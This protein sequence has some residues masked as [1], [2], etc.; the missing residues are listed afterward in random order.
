M[1]TSRAACLVAIAGLALAPAQS[2]A[3]NERVGTSVFQ[4]LRIGVGA[5]AMGMGGAFTAV[6]DDA[7]GIYWNPAGIAMVPIREVATSYLSYF[8][9][10]HAGGVAL[11][12]PVGPRAT[13]GLAAQFLRVG[14][15]PTT[16]VDNQTGQGL[17]PFS[18]NDLAISAGFGGRV[19]GG[20]YAGVAGS[21]LYE[22]I[23]A[24]DGY[25]STAVTATLGALYR[26]GFRH[27][28]VG[29]V[30]RHLGGQVSIYQFAEE[31]LPI[32]FAA[33]VATRAFWERLLVAVD[34]EKPS[35]DDAGV[36][37]G[38][39][40]QVVRD[41]FVRAGYRSLDARVGD[42]AASNGDIAGL[43]F[44]IGVSGNRRYRVDYAY[45]S[46]ADL[47]DAHRVSLALVLR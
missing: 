35:D 24:F 9:D 10:V 46:F 8:S 1:K 28:S 15:I 27:T 3:D 43:T 4:F 33:G 19:R 16:T 29:A 12:E 2:A 18:M 25:A 20:L 17:D 11:A 31:D 34:V 13:L 45:S 22:G 40:C 39:E 26:S 14:D 44:G 6:S 32:T 23:T 36:N 38:A 42:E 30:V 5:R 41:F 47:G 37:A 21:Y 7:N